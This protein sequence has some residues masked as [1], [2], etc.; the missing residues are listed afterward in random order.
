MVKLEERRIGAPDAGERP[1]AREER[2]PGPG[3]QERPERETFAPP[4]EA[5]Q[6]QLAEGGAKEGGRRKSLTGRHPF[7]ALLAAAALIAAVIGGVIWWRVSSQ[8][9]T[10]DDAF[11][12]ARFFMVAPKVGGYIEEVPVTDNQTVNAADTL[13]V[14]DPRDY[15][16]ALAQAEAQLEQAKAA[17]PNIDAQI[18]GQEAQIVQAQA[19]IADAQ[20]ALKFAVEQND[21]AQDLVKTG[22]GT[23]QAAQQTHSQ[24]LQAQAAA[25]RTKAALNAAEKQLAALKAQR[26]S[27][28]ASIDQ[29]RAQVDQAKLNLA[30][31]VVKADQAGRVTQLTASKG[32]LVQPGQSLMVIVPNLKWVVANFRETEIY[33]IH[34]GQPADITVDAYP[35]RTFKG[36]VDSIQ[37][38]SGTAFSL[39][40]PENATGNYVKVVQRVPVKIAFDEMPDVVLGPGMS[41][42][43][44]VHVQ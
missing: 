6:G 1:E 35:G 14:I 40:P 43:P 36:H 8:Y 32:Q 3:A 12:Q 28:L 4:G 41:V 18:A 23:L 21:R 37:A 16:T 9:V 20:A 5:K 11:I 15:K 24:L 25:H 19:Q 33:E 39:L 13:A 30:Y 31:T 34:P 7:L 42:V 27:A 17:I 44:W 2:R 38:G 10:T 22:A 29:A 26:V